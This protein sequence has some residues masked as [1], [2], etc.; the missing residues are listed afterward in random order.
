M[1]DNKWVS[2]TNKYKKTCSVCNRTMVTGELI[3]WNKE[4]KESMHQVEMC[5]FLGIRKKMPKRRVEESQYN[6]PVTVSY[7]K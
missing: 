3:L 7:K 4:T 5:N 1:I 6:F 2:I